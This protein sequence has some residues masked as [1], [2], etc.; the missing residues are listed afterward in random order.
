MGQGDASVINSS[1]KY[2]CMTGWRVGWMVLPRD[3]I[4]PVERLAQN[5]FICAP[6]LSQNLALCALGQ[7][8]YFDKLRED[9]ALNRVALM[10][11][12]PQ[13]GFD[14][15]LPIDGAFYAYVPRLSFAGTASDISIALDRLAGWLPSLSV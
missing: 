9:Y 2:F 14:G 13:L 1:S 7:T 3:L 11:R 12:L 4:G 15:T 8:A 10:E 6:D 5:M